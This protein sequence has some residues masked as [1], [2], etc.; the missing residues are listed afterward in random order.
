MDPDPQQREKQDPDPHQ[1]EK[2]K[3][4]VGHSGALERPNLDPNRIERWDPDPH[5]SEK[6]DPDPHQGDADP[7]HFAY[8]PQ[9]VNP[10]LLT[11]HM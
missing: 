8:R 2:V 10:V 11:K 4:L 1:S 3:V 5:Q 7:Q 6:Q 9:R